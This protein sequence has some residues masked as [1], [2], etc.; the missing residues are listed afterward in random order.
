MDEKLR[1]ILDDFSMKLRSYEESGGNLPEEVDEIWS[2]I[3]NLLM[4]ED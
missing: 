3:T 1:T 2:E 4:N